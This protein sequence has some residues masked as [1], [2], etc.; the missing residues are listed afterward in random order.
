MDRLQPT[1]RWRARCTL[2][3]RLAGR[4]AAETHAAQHSAS[5]CSSCVAGD[6]LVV[7]SLCL[8][9]GHREAERYCLSRS[10]GVHPA[11]V[12]GMG[13]D[14]TPCEAWCSKFGACMV[15]LRCR[16]QAGCPV[17]QPEVCSGG[18][19]PCLC[20]SDLVPHRGQ[21]QL[22]ECPAVASGAPVRQRDPGAVSQASLPQGQQYW[23]A[24]CAGS[25]QLPAM[26]CELRG[27][28][29]CCH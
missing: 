29:S 7:R 28:S 22:R 13:Q 10:S 1:C 20:P 6:Q 16:G 4:E 27:G 11:C 2:R 21:P 5:T 23:P 17:P 18:S 19:G 25:K 15:L 26:P 8:L 12:A 3:W 9:L 14:G 24:C